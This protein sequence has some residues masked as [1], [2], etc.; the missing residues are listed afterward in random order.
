MTIITIGR[1]Y[2]HPLLAEPAWL[3]DAVLNLTHC[4]LMLAQHRAG[5]KG[6]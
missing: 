6:P 2:R 3:R 5:E 4:R 1:W